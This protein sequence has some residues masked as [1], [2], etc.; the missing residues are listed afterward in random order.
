MCVCECRRACTWLCVHVVVC[1]CG[2]V[3]KELRATATSHTSVLDAAQDVRGEALPCR[4]TG[5]R[6]ACD[7]NCIVLRGI[8][9]TE[10]ACVR[11]E[12]RL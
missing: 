6:L 11:R 9:V 5:G 7:Y 4:P 1:A 12:V 2:C 10:R 3:C 8:T